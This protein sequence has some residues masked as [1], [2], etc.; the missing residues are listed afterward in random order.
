[1]VS[2]C[3]EIHHHAKPQKDSLRNQGV[4]LPKSTQQLQFCRDAITFRCGQRLDPT[5]SHYI[6]D[7]ITGL[8]M[9]RPSP[10]QSA[11]LRLTTKQVNGGYYKGNRTGSMGAHTEWGGYIIDY[12]KV[13]NFNCPDL[14][15]NKVRVCLSVNAVSLS[16]RPSKE[17]SCPANRHCVWIIFDGQN[18]TDETADA[19]CQCT[20]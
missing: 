5:S 12:R 4:D 7:D 16:S 8:T 18:L 9:V 13:R 14:K 15:N 11:R 19:F 10:A 6:S 20:N 2:A 17:S 3:Q 1:M